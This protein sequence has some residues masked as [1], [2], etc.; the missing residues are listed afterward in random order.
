[1]LWLAAG[2]LYSIGYGLA[3]AL[4]RDQPIA[5]CWFRACALLIPPLAGVVTI[6]LKRHAWAGCQWLF[7]STIAVGLTMSSIG[8][9]GWAFDELL[10]GRELWLAWP[11]VFA[12]FGN[13]APLFALLAQPHRGIREAHASSTAVDIAGVTV[14]TGFLYSF[15]VT[16]PDPAIGSAAAPSVSLVVVSELQ[17]AVVAVGLA[18]AVFAAR[19]TPWYRAYYRLALGSVVSFVTLSLSNVETWR[20]AYQSGFVYDFTWILPFAFYPWAVQAA[21]SKDEVESAAEEQA[22]LAR[23]RPWVIFATVALVPFLDFALRRITAADALQGF[24]DLSTAVTVISVLPLLVARIATERA[25]LQQAGSTTRLLAQVIEQTQE[26]IV[27]VTPEG[28]GRHANDAFC[29]AVGVPRGEL[30]GRQASDHVV[31]GD[32]A[33][34]ERIRLAVQSGA[35]QG[36]ATR[37]RRNGTT[38]PV[39]ASLTAIVDPAGAAKYV[40]SVERDVSEEQRLRAQLVHSERLSAVGQLVSGVAHELNNPLQSMIGTAELLLESEAREETRRDLNQVRADG[41]RAA[42]VVRSLLRFVRR[43]EG[44]RAAVDLND[45]VRSA[46]GLRRYELR[47]GGI[48]VEEAYA[49]GLPTAIVSREEIQQIVLNLILNAEQA[50]KGAGQG[51]VIVVRTGMSDAKVFAEITDD[52]PGVPAELVGR[53]FEPFFTT[54]QVGEGTGLGLSLSLGI[55]E[56]HGGT[57]VLDTTRARGAC[58]RLVLPAASS[59]PP[60]R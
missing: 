37:T 54:K 36:I 7:W 52:G 45:I 22:E 16:T 23:P 41:Q 2:V 27:V 53:I 55:A 9:S 19:G 50:L 44:E 40:V 8:L 59:Q 42:Q 26:L 60:N 38:F 20:G 30:E 32:A 13:V 43:S 5:L 51:G 4:W 17:A 39:A 35:W 34:M 6:V 25:E 49:P 18:A 28:H 21:P 33:F 57:L 14:V 46:L 1:M 24:R 48:E 47:C 11:A 3:G 58:F 29:R 10:L 12:L 15:F 56:A 31:V